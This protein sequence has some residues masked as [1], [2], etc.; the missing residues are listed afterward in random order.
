MVIYTYGVAYAILPP[1]MALRT[2]VSPR[3]T[4]MDLLR[5]IEACAE[6]TSGKP[7][8]LGIT[9]SAVIQ[10][11]LGI[12]HYHDP[13]LEGHRFATDGVD[14][15]EGGAE[16]VAMH[17]VDLVRKTELLRFGSVALLPYTVS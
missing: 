12:V 13:V 9:C 6:K 10:D 4:P 2:L 11:G 16:D 5:S 1:L 8:D 3:F 17:T 14:V 7:V 15:F